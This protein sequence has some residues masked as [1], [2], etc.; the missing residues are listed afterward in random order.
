MTSNSLQ[1]CTF[2]LC[3]DGGSFLSLQ[4]NPESTECTA[5]R[6]CFQTALLSPAAINQTFYHLSDDTWDCNTDP[7][8]RHTALHTRREVCQQ[9]DSQR[10]GGGHLG[11]KCLRRGNM[12]INL[13]KA[14][15]IGCVLVFYCSQLFFERAETCSQ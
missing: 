15:F 8:G 11:C 7:V 6:L 2:C 9:W 5:G 13:H 4:N 10:G 1:R 3:A 14:L 12:F